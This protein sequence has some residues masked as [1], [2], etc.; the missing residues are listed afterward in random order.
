MWTVE[1]A[2]KWK[3]GLASPQTSFGVR[4]LR[5][6][7]SPRGINYCV[8]NEPQRTSAGRLSV[9]ANR[10]MRFWWHENAYFYCAFQANWRLRFSLPSII[11]ADLLGNNFTKTGS[12]GYGLWSVIRFVWVFQGSLLVIVIMIDHSEKRNCED[13]FWTL[14]FACLWK[15]QW[16]RFCVD[17]TSIILTDLILYTIA[18]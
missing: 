17:R 14:E 5:I 13:G 12:K 15:A 6:H 18:K 4:L 3:C 1:N 11:L 9:D 8:T 10:P 2:S 16:K 7:F